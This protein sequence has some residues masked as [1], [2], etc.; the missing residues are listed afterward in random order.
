MRSSPTRRRAT[1]WVGVFVAKTGG[2]VRVAVT[3][4]GPGVFRAAEMEKALAASFTADA[5][6][7][8]QGQGRRPQQRYPRQR[9]LSRPSRHRDGAPRRRRRIGSRNNATAVPL[10]AP[11]GE[12]GEQKRP[13]PSPAK[14]GVHPSSAAP[15]PA[16]TPAFAG[17]TMGVGAVGASHYAVVVAPRT[18]QMCHG[19]IESCL[20]SRAL[21][22][23]KPV[24]CH[25]PWQ[26]CRDRLGE[27]GCPLPQRSGGAGAR[28]CSHPLLLA[29]IAAVIV[30][31][32]AAVPGHRHHGAARPHDR[33]RPWR[34]R[35]F[36]VEAIGWHRTV[37]HRPSPRRCRRD[38]HRTAGRR[39]RPPWRCSAITSS[40]SRSEAAMSARG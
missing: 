38:R 22:P 28:G 5:I 37:I 9:R 27:A 11:A 14:S 25:W 31:I 21:K 12:G 18:H 8:N 35:A 15:V 19:Q 20:D 3:G 2:A 34:S 26:I 40:A 13:L 7:A 1:Q 10:P 24:V 36:T 29:A 39:I 17:V 23:P 30:T 33:G 6:K 16:S 4:A 32:W